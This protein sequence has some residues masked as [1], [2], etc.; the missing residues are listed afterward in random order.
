VD[1]QAPQHEVAA[2]T[3]R[4]TGNGKRSDSGPLSG[5]CC[6]ITA[7]GLWPSACELQAAGSAVAAGTEG[8]WIAAKAHPAT[9]TD[10][11]SVLRESDD[12][13]RQNAPNP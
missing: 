1:R 2:A 4:G 6:S 8:S 5:V 7:A 13:D 12:T 9:I 11:L 10:S 3:L